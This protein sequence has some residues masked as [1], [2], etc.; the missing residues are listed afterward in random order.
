MPSFT[1]PNGSTV[2]IPGP[3][4][5]RMRD[6]YPEESTE[7]NAKCRI[8]HPGVQFVIEDSSAVVPALKSENPHIGRLTL[9]TKSPCG[10][11]ARSRGG[12]SAL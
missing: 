2:S 9:R 5:V 7:T 10:S 12:R 4:V 6:A 11:M 3:D 8:D 1:A